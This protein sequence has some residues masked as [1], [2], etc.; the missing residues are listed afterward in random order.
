MATSTI[1]M[2]KSYT[3]GTDGIWTYRKYEDGTYHAWYE[4]NVN[5]MAGTA[6]LGGYYH[7]TK[8]DLSAPSFSRTITSL[9]AAPNGSQL[10]AYLG[11]TMGSGNR[12]YFLDGVSTAQD[13]KPVRIDMYG[14]W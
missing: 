10:F 3:S 8:S 13:G 2:R 4:G 12:L 1:P 5:F 6:W 14:T 7:S 11:N 9:T